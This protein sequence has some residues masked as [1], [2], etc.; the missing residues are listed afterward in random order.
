MLHEF[1]LQIQNLKKELGDNNNEIE[2]LKTKLD[3]T[4]TDKNVSN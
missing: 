1:S 3:K 2:Q 4:L